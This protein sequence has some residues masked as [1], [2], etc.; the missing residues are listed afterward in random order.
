M[1]AKIPERSPGLSR[2]RWL[3]ANRL[4]LR[5]LGGSP[6]RGL[7]GA[8]VWLAD[9]DGEFAEGR[10][11][12]RAGAGIVPRSGRRR[13][14]ADR[15]NAHP[16]PRA[17]NIFGAFHFGKPS[18]GCPAGDFTRAWPTTWSVSSAVLQTARHATRR[19]QPFL[20]RPTRGEEVGFVGALAHFDRYQNR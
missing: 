10:L 2:Q 14:R 16:R 9:D 17:N 18:S 6:V 8:R 15:D 5:W 12:N 11:T 19:A 4:A 20:V 3:S 1:G 13:G 7:N